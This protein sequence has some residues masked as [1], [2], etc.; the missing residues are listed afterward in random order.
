M[1]NQDKTKEELKKELRELQ[2]EL[3]IALQ[4]I[5][6]RNEEKEKRADEL[7]IANIELDF[8]VEEKGK[9][10][11][12][13]VIANKERLFQNEEKR[14]RAAELILAKIKIVTQGEKNEK[15]AAE[16]IIANLALVLQEELIEAKEKAEESE[17]KFHNIF[18]NSPI[19]KSITGIDGSL[20]VNQAFCDILGYSKNEME[21]NKWQGITFSE[22]IDKSEKIAQS[23]LQGIIKQ[24]RFEKRYVH[25]NGNIIYAEVSTF[26]QWDND[27]NPKFFI[28]AFNDVT[29][30]RLAEKELIQAKEKAEGNERK[31]RSLFNSMQEGVYLNEL[32]YD[33][34]GKAINYKIIEANPIS[35]K[36]LNIKREKAIGKLATELFETNVAPFIEIYAKVVETGEPFAF[37][38]YFKPMD[39]HFLIS[40][41]TP[42]KGEFATVFL[43]ITE[44]KEHETELIKAKE[45]AEESENKF[46]QLVWDM[47]VGVLLQGPQTEILLSNP[48]ALELLGLSEDQLL[49]KT[50]FDPDWNVI[51]EDGSPFPGNTH[52][53]S[54]AIATCKSVYGVIMGVYHPVSNERVWL[55]VDAIPQLNI[56]R[57][58]QQVVCSF[59][60]I[61]VRKKAEQELNKAKEKAE[62]SDRLKSAFLANMSH[63]IRTPMNGILGFSS[64]L[65]EPKL[66]GEEQQKYIG[67]IEK[68]GVRML[69]IINDIISISKIE[70]GLMEVNMEASNVNE[71]IEYIHTFFKPEAEAKGI[72]LSFKNSLPL[73]DAIIKTDREKLFAILTNLVKNAIKYTAKGSIEFGYSIKG[74]QFEFYVKDTGIGIDE[75]RQIAIFERF[76]QADIEDK[77]AR[78]GAGLGL[79]IS[80]AYVEILGGELWVESKKDIGSTFYFTIPYNAE[81]MEI[82]RNTENQETKNLTSPIKK[83][84]ILIVEDDETSNLFLN[85]I[86][87]EQKTEI[88]CAT[89]GTE[90]IKLC[91]E[92]PDL[93]L[94][95]MDIK[96]P[97][98]D[99]YEA[100]KQIREFNKDVVIIAQTAHGLAG[101]REKAMVAGCNEHIPK[102]I[103]KKKLLSLIEQYFIN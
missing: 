66:T 88:I 86:L 62:E 97:D 54:V 1:D 82:Y 45:K 12:E 6:I 90:A 67:I 63:E 57:T 9:R 83:L 61:S 60:D 27:N 21:T 3:A 48:A 95:L 18:E 8:Q 35:E 25:K 50:S 28:T 51:H 43:D 23:L 22:D 33:K 13:L 75:D 10:A 31:F 26:L 70:S 79:A 93:D 72:T 68:S 29:D 14:K 7:D 30:L 87:K 98:M 32:I 52:P 99:G 2:Q 11:A 80:K 36:Y 101:D 5:T 71:Q 89:T 56:N 37:E 74:E 96:M 34:L 100:T 38:Q 44:T 77:M 81:K 76:I 92:N 42:N 47:N 15:L 53:V 17:I 94:I 19:A 84:K 102:P 64:L 59:I 91:R 40:V 49:G 69:N 46:K 58:I 78:Q 16:L 85:T 41:F 65:K 20:L 103:E 4:E 55:L 73:K 24:A 39:R